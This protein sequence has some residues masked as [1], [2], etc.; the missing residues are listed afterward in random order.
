MSWVQP[1]IEQIVGAYLREHPAVRAVVSRVVSRTPAST[2]TP[3]VRYQQIAEQPGGGMA[4]FL[5]APLLQFDCYAGRDNSRETASLIA[6]TVRAA[7]VEMEGVHGGAVIT[8]VPPGLVSVSRLPDPD[9]GDPA[10]ER[11]VVTATVYCH[12]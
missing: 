1:D 8:G 4:D 5:I 10:R 6:R 3:W 11:Y 9:L 2:D 12:G 7:L